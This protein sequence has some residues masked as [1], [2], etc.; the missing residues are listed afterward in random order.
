MGK[1][2]KKVRNNKMDKIYTIGK[3]I[4]Y[5]E[6]ERNKIVCSFMFKLMEANM[7]H[8]LTTEIR[9]NIFKYIRSGIFYEVS[10][11][12]PEYGSILD[13][14]LS[15]ERNSDIYINFRSFR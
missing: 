15:N 8:V 2:S 10:L 4:N 14:K 13:I 11:E 5:T 6:S 12:L 3:P 1:K 9:E 7:S